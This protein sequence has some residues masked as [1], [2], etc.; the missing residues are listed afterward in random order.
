[1]TFG[2][3][4]VKCLYRA[5]SLMAVPKEISKYKLELVGVQE[6]RF[7]RG[8]TEPPGEHTFFCRNEIE[9]DESGTGFFLYIRESIK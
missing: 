8:G 1:V 6:V 5:G 3:W 2:A 4:S 9:N 7:E